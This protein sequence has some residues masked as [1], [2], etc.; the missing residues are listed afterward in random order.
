MNT[1]LAEHQV[2]GA[3]DKGERISPNSEHK[4]HLQ[5]QSEGQRSL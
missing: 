2:D 3:Q 4:V 1:D 5:M